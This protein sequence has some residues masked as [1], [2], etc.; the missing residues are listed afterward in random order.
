LIDD[1][2]TAASPERPVPPAAEAYAD[3]VRRHAY[4][5]TDAQVEALLEAGMS[6]D[7]VFEVTVAAAVGAGL[8]RL[9]AG[10][11]AMQ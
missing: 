2:R 11:R 6:E 1:L 4:R 5:T 10:L 9:D 8:E 3:T 7:E